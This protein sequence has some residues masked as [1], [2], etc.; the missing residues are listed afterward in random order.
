MKPK[1]KRR[2]VKLKMSAKMRKLCPEVAAMND[3]AN[4]LKK[5]KRRVPRHRYDRALSARVEDWNYKV[6]CRC[7]KRRP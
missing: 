5:S 1:P 3:G 2:K 7:G 4:V 6:L